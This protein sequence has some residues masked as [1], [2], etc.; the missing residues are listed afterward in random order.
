MESLTVASAGVQRRNLSSLQPLPPPEFKRFSCLSLPSSWDYRHVLDADNLLG[1]VQI[2]NITVCAEAYDIALDITFPKGAE[3]GLDFGIVRVTEEVKQPLQ[4]KNRG[5]YEIG[6]SF[7]V[8]SLGISTP[9]INSMIS[10]Q[11]KKG[12]LTPTEKPTN[13]QVFFRAKKE[14][15]IEHQPVLRCQIIEPSIS[16]GHEIIAS[17][18][19][20]FSVNAVYSKYNISPSSIINFGALI[21][22]ARK[23]STFTIENQGVTDFKFALYRLTGESP[24]HQKK[25]V[26]HIRRARSRESESFYKTG[27]SKAAKFSDSIQKEMISTSQARFSHGMFTVY[28]WFGSI[29]AGGQQVINVDCVADPVGRCEEFIAIDISGRDPADQPTGIPYTLLAEASLPAFVTENNA[30]IFE[31]HQICTS[32]NLYHILQTIE[33]GGLFVEDENKFIFCNVLVGHQAKARFK[34]SNVGKIAC[35][36]NVVVR[37]I[38][39]KRWGFIMLAKLIL[40]SWA[41]ASLPPQPP[42]VL[43]SQE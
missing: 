26:S 34:I 33:S 43:K 35:D 9:N 40:N 28:P 12:S 1:V 41:Q 27:C 4:L 18:P 6:F 11:P 7:S 24:I 30:L 5:K 16:E 3:G 23:S 29:P 32:A 13:V 20:K 15:K 39:N 21:C 38:S 17:I 22:G 19:I 8:D 31:E 10:V 42:K 25:A 36:V 14:V 2:E 37:P